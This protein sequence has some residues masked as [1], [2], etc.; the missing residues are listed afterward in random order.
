MKTLSLKLLFS[1]LALWSSYG[2]DVVVTTVL[3]PVSLVVNTTKTPIDGNLYNTVTLGGA[4]N[5]GDITTGNITLN[6]SVFNAAV[7]ALG[8]NDYLPLVVGNT[9]ILN[10]GNVTQLGGLGDNIITCQNSS[11][12]G[13]PHITITTVENSSGQKRNILLTAAGDITFASQSIVTPQAGTNQAIAIDSNGNICST[14]GAAL[15]VLGDNSLINQGNF[16]SLDN[17]VNQTGIILSTA[18]LTA[19]SNNIQ[20][21]AGLNNINLAFASSSSNTYNLLA[22]DSSGNLKELSSV[23]PAVFGSL[24]AAGQN[25]EFVNLGVAGEN[26]FFLS[27]SAN[28]VI[29]TKAGYSIILDSASHIELLSSDLT[30]GPLVA[31]VLALNSTNAIE[32]TDKSAKFL[33]GELNSSKNYITVDNSVTSPTGIIVNGQL[34]ITGLPGVSA[35][36]SGHTAALT[37]DDT[38][39]VGIVISDITKK[40]NVKD[41]A[42]GDDFYNLRPISYT[43]KGKENSAT[44][45]GLSAQELRGTSCESAIIWGKD[46]EPVSIDYKSIFT[47][48]ISKFIETRNVLLSKVNEL[49][50]KINEKDSVINC[51]QNEVYSLKEKSDQLKLLIDLLAQKI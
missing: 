35:L 31:T 46:G 20:L 33:I 44:E 16:I 14:N 5:I 36:A 42:I 38:G 9:G 50:F 4:I 19:G 1:S 34:K 30:N 8:P 43:I 6:S 22:I 25:G 10:A 11:S 40:E 26:T 47:A 13:M 49:E 23:S 24:T 15:I 45:F 21:N 27:S 28:T 17:S 39:T 32:T 12:T 37:I 51:L 41:L 7:Q 2:T 48:A 18:G 3:G 29:N